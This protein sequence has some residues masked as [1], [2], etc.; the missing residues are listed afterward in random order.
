MRCQPTIF[1]DRDGTLME[2][3]G[4]VRHPEE[5]QLIPNVLEALALFRTK[6]YLLFLVSNQSG[7]GRGIISKEQFEQVHR[8]FVDLLVEAGQKLD[9]FRYCFHTPQDQC[10]CRKPG[11][12]NIPKEVGGIPIDF[13]RSYVIGDRMADIGLGHN[14]GVVPFLVHTVFGLTTKEML[15]KQ[16]PVKPWRQASDLLEVAGLV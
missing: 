5:V 13:E 11:T 2:D 12:A 3:T 7:V 14:L 1:L 4:Y 16:P 8:R 6:G 9:G 15:L 10:R